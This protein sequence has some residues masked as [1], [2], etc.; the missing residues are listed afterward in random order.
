MTAYIDGHCHLNSEEF[1]T[2]LLLHL[3]RARAAGVGRMLVVGTDEA[4]SWKAL[5]MART[6]GE[7]GVWA[8]VGVHPH[9]A[10][11]VAQGLPRSLWDLASCS[12]VCAVGEIG[13]DYHYEYSPRSIQ[14]EVLIEQLEWAREVD[15]PVVF[16]VR[17]A[18]D[19]FFAILRDNPVSRAG[20]VVHCFTGTWTQA[21][22]CLDLGLYLG[23]GGMI[24]FKKADNLRSCLAGA[25][26]DRIILETDSPWLA[27]VPY[28][29]K[30][31]TPAFMP[32]IYGA[33]AQVTGHSEE[34][35]VRAVWD[36]AMDLYGWG[37]R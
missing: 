11:S 24:T 25:P 32:L 20:G 37:T 8:A 13:L 21:K 31:N 29:G 7:R 18:F 2:D 36:N 33:A 35:V 26:L 6:Y 19:D 28:R 22:A 3:D 12:D 9:D 4:S 17:E 16:H 34:T 30:L 10:L 5:E 14:R 15:R 23:F 1:E 27:P